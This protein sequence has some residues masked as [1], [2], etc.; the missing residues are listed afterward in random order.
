MAEKPMSSNSYVDVNCIVH[1]AF[2]YQKVTRNS[3]A[4]VVLKL[5]YMTGLQY[6][7]L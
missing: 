7:T 1:V 4:K 5:T 6:A 3:G 2:S